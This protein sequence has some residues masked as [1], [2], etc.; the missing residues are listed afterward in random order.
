MISSGFR[1]CNYL[2]KV[3]FPVKTHILISGFLVLCTFSFNI[4]AQNV[5]KLVPGK[6]VVM[7]GNSITFQGNREEVL[8]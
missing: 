3:Y 4:E 7:Y 8:N 5:S 1:I 6:V 2:S